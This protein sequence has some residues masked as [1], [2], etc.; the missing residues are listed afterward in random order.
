MTFGTEAKVE[1][2]LGDAKVDTLKKAIDAIG[3]VNYIGGATASALALQEVRK[4]VVPN[5]RKGSKRAMMFITDGM[6]NIGG[7]PEKEAD[8]LKDK[9]EFEIYAIGKPY[10]Y[11]NPIDDLDIKATSL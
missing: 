4:V 8:Y 6:S 10:F 5:A 1:F 7:S 11:Y 3:K 2:N 9:E